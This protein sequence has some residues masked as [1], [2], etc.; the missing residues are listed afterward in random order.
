MMQLL[1]F[2]AVTL[3]KV[4][5]EVSAQWIADADTECEAHLDALTAAINEL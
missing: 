4:A 3:A 5:D 2:K 1:L